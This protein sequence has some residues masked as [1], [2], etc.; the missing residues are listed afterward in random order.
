MKQLLFSRLQITLSKPTKINEI[1]TNKSNNLFL[2][3]ISFDNRL[4]TSESLFELL[5]EVLSQDPSAIEKLQSYKWGVVLFVVFV[6]HEFSLVH[7]L[8]VQNVWKYLFSF[9][10][11]VCRL[12]FCSIQASDN[13]CP[14][15]SF[16]ATW[17][18]LL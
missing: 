11:Q 17:Q 3:C 7:L 10:Q 1:F 6:F 18:I 13:L 2:L 9:L 15:Y 4:T 5:C 8:G 14:V 12:F 16:Q